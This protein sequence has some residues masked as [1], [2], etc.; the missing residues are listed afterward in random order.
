ME[1]PSP[2]IH[3]RQQVTMQMRD[4]P[5][6]EISGV[7]NDINCTSKIQNYKREGKKISAK[8]QKIWKLYRQQTVL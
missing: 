5:T 2:L 7:S 6:F 8:F 3:L 1:C 4:K